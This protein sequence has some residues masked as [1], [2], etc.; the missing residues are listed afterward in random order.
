MIFPV[1]EEGTTV[2]TDEFPAYIYAA[3]DD[4]FEHK[5]INHLERYVDG[6]VHTNG[7]EN[8]W[9]CLKRGLGGTY[10]AV[11]PFHFS[12]TSMNRRSA[13]T[14]AQP[15]DNPLNDA[16]RFHF[17][18]VADRRKAA[19]FCGGDWQGAGNAVLVPVV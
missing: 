10:I 14:I 9:S 3:K 7:I 1:I 17:G 19:D 5:V 16:D 11:E 6:N 12:V 8:F 13:S 2:Y 18:N 15:Q 4:E